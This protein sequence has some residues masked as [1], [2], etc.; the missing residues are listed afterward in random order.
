M[1]IKILHRTAFV[2]LAIFVASAAANAQ[3]S[4][5]AS[6]NTGPG[7]QWPASS[8]G[9]TYIPVCWENP[10]GWQN[11]TLSVRNTILT[12]WGRAAKVNFYGWAQCTTN[13]KGIRILIADTRSNSGIGRFL[14]G[15]RNGMELNFTFRNF[16]PGCQA[17][18]RRYA[19]ITSIAVHE[20]GHALGLMH[21]QDRADSTCNAEKSKS[22]G[23]LLTAYDPDSV[24]NYCNPRWNNDGRLSPLD[25]KGIQILYGARTAAPVTP[26]KPSV[27]PGR[28]TITD[29]LNVAAGQR[30]EHI[31]MQFG[32]NNIRRDFALNENNRSVT[33]SW[34]FNT[35]GTYCF[36]IWSNTLYTDGLYY[37]GYGEGCWQLEAGKSY[38]ASVRFKTGTGKKAFDIVLTSGN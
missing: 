6:A 13:A 1:T 4:A 31:I 18:N 3:S 16:S 25:I 21:E 33:N 20:F 28:L 27:T 2:L 32:S 37:D 22:G 29:T 35:T 24:M 12:T 19:C 23:L 36:K 38:A 17:E 8:D 15:D 30:W 11:E 9:I 14:D 26:P 10:A 7:W 5:R 34:T